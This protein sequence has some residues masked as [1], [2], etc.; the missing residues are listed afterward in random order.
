MILSVVPLWVL[1]YEHIV[2][3]MEIIAG[4]HFPTSSFAYLVNWG[5]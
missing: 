4:N 5:A 1:G 3:A 2:A